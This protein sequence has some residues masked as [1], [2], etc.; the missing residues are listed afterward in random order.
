MSDPPQ[1]T[2]RLFTLDNLQRIELAPD[3]ILVVMTDAKLSPNALSRI[4]AT[5][6]SA[7]AGRKLLILDGGLKLGIIK[8]VA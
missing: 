4:E 8:P 3:D 5:M 6:E 2:G 7:F 1:I